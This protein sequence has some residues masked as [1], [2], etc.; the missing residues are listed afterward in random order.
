M[1]LLK[2]IG[3]KNRLKIRK[4]NLNL[5]YNKMDGLLPSL[6]TLLGGSSGGACGMSQAGGRRRRSRSR[7]SASKSRS[8]SRSR[9]KSRG[10]RRRSRSRSMVGGRRHLSGGNM[11]DFDMEG[12]RRRRRKS[13]GDEESKPKRRRSRSRKGR[14]KSR[15]RSRK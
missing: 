1:Q 12:G 8:R 14:R 4:K 5:I 9:S 3:G 6:T 11:M 7:K 10:R 13:V 15:S 2:L